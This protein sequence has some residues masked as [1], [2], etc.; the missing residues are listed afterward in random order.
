MPS[1]MALN[2]GGQNVL[3]RM[4]LEGEV[5]WGDTSEQETNGEEEEAEE[6]KRHR[7]ESCNVKDSVIYHLGRGKRGSG[8]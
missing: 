5:C 4:G 6:S 8:R 7:K 3:D 2:S 1:V